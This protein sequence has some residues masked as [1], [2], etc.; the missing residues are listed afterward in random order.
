MVCIAYGGD[1]FVDS[2]LSNLVHVVIIFR[3]IEKHVVFVSSKPRRYVFHLG[4]TGTNC[5]VSLR[6]MDTPRKKYEEAD[7]ALKTDF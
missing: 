7:R 3:G 6:D 5:S 1:V 4:K 2:V